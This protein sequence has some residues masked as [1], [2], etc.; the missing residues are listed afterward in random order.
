MNIGKVVGKVWATKRL[1]MFPAGALVEV[2]LEPSGGRYV[3]FD[4]IG[5]SDEDRVLVLL[6]SAA[7][8]YFGDTPVLVDAITVAI[9]DEDST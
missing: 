6:S 3:C 9:L 7:A 8:R 4:P 2:E 1:D 5:C